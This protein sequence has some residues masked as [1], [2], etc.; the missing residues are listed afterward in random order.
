MILNFRTPGT[1]GLPSVWRRTVI[2]ALL[3]TVSI[4]APATYASAG[5]TAQRADHYEAKIPESK[6]DAAIMAREA[7]ASIVSAFDAGDFELIHKQT[8]KL[9]AAAKG[10]ARALEDDSEE[11]EVLAYRIEIV[12][13]ASELGDGAVLK[14][15]IP[16]LNETLNSVLSELDL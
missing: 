15:A 3:I 5:E 10:I 14:P 12:H 7:M 11:A 9:E 8:Y 13:L 1:A 4:I 2:A 16:G 6:M